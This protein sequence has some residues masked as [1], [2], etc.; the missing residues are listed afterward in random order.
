[1]SDQDQLIVVTLRLDLTLLVDQDLLLFELPAPSHG[2]WQ[3][4]R[5]NFACGSSLAGVGVPQLHV[6]ASGWLACSAKAA[7]LVIR[8]SGPMT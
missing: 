1:V 7:L 5:R 8:Q 4:S 2:E 6:S 3:N